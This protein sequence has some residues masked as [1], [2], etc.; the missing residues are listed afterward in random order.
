MDTDQETKRALR[1]AGLYGL[2]IAVVVIGGIVMLGI[3]AMTGMSALMRSSQVYKGAL[4]RVRADPEVVAAFG[5]PIEPGWLLVGSIETSG[6]SGDAS[7][8]GQIH[9][10]LRR[11]RIYIGAR[12][13]NGVWNYYT[14]AVSVRGIDKMITVNR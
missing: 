8:T 2:R 13:E 11:G 6:L 14:L 10:P 9:G 12:R 1:F 4:E 3:L 5:E 7:L